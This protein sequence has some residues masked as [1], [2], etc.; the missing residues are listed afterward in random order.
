MFY[1][2][3]V[4]RKHRNNVINMPFSKILPRHARLEPLFKMT[5][6]FINR[7]TNKGFPFSLT[8]YSRTKRIPHSYS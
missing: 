3:I 2:L 6:K 4:K 7:I 8:L 5:F 1:F